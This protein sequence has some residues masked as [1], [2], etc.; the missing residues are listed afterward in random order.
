LG[1]GLSVR[2]LECTRAGRRIFSG[3]SFDV[4]PGEAVQV[5]GAN[6]SG[7]SSLLRLLCGLLPPS[8]GAVHWCSRN[9]GSRDAGLTGDLAYMGHADGFSG[10]LTVLENLRFCLRVAGRAEADAERT[11][12]LHQLRLAHRAH[13]QVRHLSQGQRRRLNLAR[14]VLSRRRLWLLDEPCAGLDTQGEQRFDAYLAAH[15]REG[16]LAVVTTHRDIGRDGP[17]A[18]AL[19]MDAFH[20]DSLDTDH[21]P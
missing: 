11:E 4:A 13:E 5:R 10:D 7:K 15:L 20:A 16:G 2:D 8:R 19:E 1:N 3:V 14:V 6:G 12:V 21:R 18:R 17:C 9:I